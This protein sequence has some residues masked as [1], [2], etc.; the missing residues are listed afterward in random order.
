MPP[1]LQ[2]IV[3]RDGA[4]ETLNVINPQ[5]V[6][7]FNKARKAWVDGGGEL[8]SLPRD[9]QTQMLQMLASVGD[10]VSKAKPSLRAAYETVADVARRLRPSPTQ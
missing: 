5:A 10:D 3:D 8:I 4:N 9:E 7:F 1:D 6:D 2:Q